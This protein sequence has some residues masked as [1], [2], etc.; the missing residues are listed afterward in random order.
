MQ[1]SRVPLGCGSGVD[2]LSGQWSQTGQLWSASQ[3]PTPPEG[4]GGVAL[5]QL[6]PIV[7]EPSGVAGLDTG[8]RTFRSSCSSD[9]LSQGFRKALDL[10]IYPRG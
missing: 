7:L 5:K 3:A 10:I 8:D 2:T 6:L 9:F 4:P 1:G